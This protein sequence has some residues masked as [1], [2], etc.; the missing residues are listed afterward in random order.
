[1]TKVIFYVLS[2]TTEQEK[3]IF[4][5]KLLEKIYL[6]QLCCYVLTDNIEQ[7]KNLDNLLWT[8]RPSSFVPHQLFMGEKFNSLDKILI[9]TDLPPEGWQ[10][11]IVNLSSH[12]PENT[13]QTTKILE[14]VNNNTASKE[15]GR[16]HYRQ[17]QQFG[18]SIKTH[19]I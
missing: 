1:M 3:L 5:C 14:I 8:F 18:L 4:V 11:T 2:S 9:G 17:Y 10:E 12:C 7:S 13:L 19:Q 15:R 16:Q 6:K